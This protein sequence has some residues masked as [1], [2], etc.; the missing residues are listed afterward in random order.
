MKTWGKKVFCSWKF[1][2]LI[3][4]IV[5]HVCFTQTF[6]H[7]QDMTQDQFLIRV[8]LVWIQ[9]FLLDCLTKAK[10]P[11]LPYYLPIA[12]ERWIHALG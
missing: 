9:S 2:L 12:T 8:K 1:A 10:E 6:H 11:S 3:G 5:Q 7:K 4:I